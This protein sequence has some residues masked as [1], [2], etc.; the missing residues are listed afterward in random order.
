MTIA[1]PY[2]SKNKRAV[3]NRPKSQLLLDR[4]N[5]G[6]LSVLAHTLKAYNAVN[7]S[8]ERIIG[9]AANIVTGVDVSTSLLNENVTG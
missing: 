2:D 4:I 3:L 1:R 7:L 5:A 8:E 6:A 9:T